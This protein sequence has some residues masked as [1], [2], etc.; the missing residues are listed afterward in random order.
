MD[1]YGSRVLCGHF[2]T[3]VSSPLAIFLLNSLCLATMA[4]ISACDL[5]SL[6]HTL[7]H[8]DSLVPQYLH[9]VCSLFIAQYLAF[10]EVQSEL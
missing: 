10:A 4:S 9:M 6:E 5:I 2:L 7:L 3:L 1:E 8:F